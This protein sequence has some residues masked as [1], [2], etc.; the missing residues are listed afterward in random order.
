MDC[1]KYCKLNI[2]VSPETSYL[3]CVK[4]YVTAHLKCVAD[5]PLLICDTFYNFT[6]E[7]CSDS[8]RMFLTRQ[9]LT[10]NCVLILTLYN[11]KQGTKNPCDRNGYYHW[12]LH[13][14]NFIEKNWKIF[15]GIKKKPNLWQTR[16]PTAL[17]HTPSLFKSGT[18]ELKEQG[19]WKLV[20]ID[21]PQKIYDNYKTKLATT[22]ASRS[23]QIIFEENETDDCIR[24][25]NSDSFDDNSLET[26]LRMDC[27]SNWDMQL[28]EMTCN[29][30][31]LV[32]TSSDSPSTTSSH[33]QDK[34]YSCDEEDK[35]EEESD[36]ER[37][38]QQEKK[39]SNIPDS[40]KLWPWETRREENRIKCQPMS[41]YEELMLLKKLSHTI[42]EADSNSVPGYVRRFYR[43]L[44]VRK[45]KRERN[46]PLFS[47]D[48]QE[49]S[50]KNL[51]RILD[52]Y[53]NILNCQQLQQNSFLVDQ[54]S[55]SDKSCSISPY[56]Q[57]SLKP[58]IRI[59]H[60]TKPPW[61]CLMDD[62]IK[63]RG[64]EPDHHHPITYSYVKAR[65]IPSINMLCAVY[66]WPGV[67]LSECLQYPDFSCVVEYKRLIIGFAFMVP[68]VSQTEAY[69]SFI[70]TR[71]EWRRAGI[72]KF[73]LYHLIQTC[74]GKDVT[75]HVSATNPAI[76][77]Y[78]MFGFKVEEF[79]LDFYD[80]YFP[81]NSKECR[82]ALFLRL[83]R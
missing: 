56:T 37:Q 83:N 49:C 21:W 4:C 44:V 11:L 18:D 12:K 66:F 39:K 76:L 9:H 45:I 5:K 48:S 15:F 47:L 64:L 23:K 53:Q 24:L 62:I 58:L 34:S 42:Q 8:K 36:A 29:D 43:K 68:D 22:E 59:D 33:I 7:K 61:L 30:S 40:R 26:D 73:M 65:H 6:C 28:S 50:N 38:S 10:W 77:L 81:Y 60:E 52:R 71:P 63:Y 80:K 57:R 19:W 14:S 20:S 69:I 2:G 51:P 79:V 54:E 16:I 1:C 25:L 17:S 75:L 27:I 41:E 32:L 72:A 70:F 35:S 31:S 67:D 55:T 46:L 82:H 13:I 78:Q 74:M 3:K